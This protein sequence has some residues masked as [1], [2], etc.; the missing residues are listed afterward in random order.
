MT[1]INSINVSP[2]NVTIGVGSWYYGAY[3]QI[4]STDTNC[5]CNCNYVSWHSDNTSV[6]TVNASS[7]YIYGKAAG[8][9]R[10]YATAQD[11]SGISDYI[12]VTVV[13][14]MTVTSIQLNK[15]NL[16]L[17]EGECY[18]LSATVYPSN[19][20]NKTLIWHSN[21]TCVATVCDGTVCAVSVG[22]ATITATS[23]DGSGKS[24]TCRVTVTDDVL[25]TS[26]TV[27]PS[28][29]TMYAGSSYYLH[30]TVF[31]CDA[32]NKNVV[33]SST[34]TF[35]ATVNPTSGLVYAKSAGDAMIYATAQD[36][37]GVRGICNISVSSVAVSSVSICPKQK[38]LSPGETTTLSAV[39]S[40]SCASNKSVAWT[41][42]D[43]SVAT[44]GTYTGVVT[45]QS[46]G[47]AT[48]TAR[49]L[50]DDKTDICTITVDARE[51]V[52]VKKDSHSFFVQF[53]D[54][55]V[56]KNIGID[57]SNRQENYN[58]MYPPNMWYENYDY[59]IEE[60]QRYF[61]NIYV[62]SGGVIVDN[63]SYSA[64]QIGFLYLL[65]PLGIE[66]YMRNHACHDMSLGEMLF[67]KDTVYKEIFGVWPRLIKVF[68]DKTIRYYVYSTS[69]SADDRADYY[70]D[71][72]ILFGEHPIYDMLS[73]IS[74]LLDVVPGVT[75]SLFSIFY[76][77]A[78]VVLGSIDLVKFLFFSASATSILS[79]GANSIMEEYTSNIYTMS[80]GE[81]AGVK[82]GKAMKWVNFVLGSFSTILNAAE[83]FTPSLNDITTYNRINES[84]YR[85]SYNVSGSELSMSDIIARIS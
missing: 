18:T 10:I 16:S 1:C 27:S 67:F 83:V 43:T 60:E 31:P 64:Q 46:D 14:G 29:Q 61:D 11:G 69:L 37:S 20:N 44:V 77:P 55:K 56:W 51:K 32:A 25:V 38:T 65:D 41:S 15:T 9:A 30:A 72:E 3:A 58:H 22:T 53:E 39:I 54:G 57:L 36:G 62:A 40:P 52:Y 75:S 84:N 12:T 7:G 6:A 33:W 17:E 50:N 78:G 85:V 48:I 24:A 68:P 70:T 71:A 23:T 74:F 45:A 5:N 80:G 8:T 73:F 76:P 63:T 47:T 4:C 81:S 66:Y 26:I 34:N 35:I 28:C 42:S 82:A 49:V 59:L 19:A 2:K 21:N 79:S 13:N